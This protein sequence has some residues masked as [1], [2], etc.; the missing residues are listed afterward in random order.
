[1][2][3]TRSEAAGRYILGL[4]PAD[5]SGYFAVTE[6]V[7]TYGGNEV[8]RWTGLVRSRRTFKPALLVPLD[9]KVPQISTGATPQETGRILLVPQGADRVAGDLE[10]E[11]DGPE[12][13]ACLSGNGYAEWWLDIPKEATYQVFLRYATPNLR[14]CDIVIDGMDLNEHTMCALNKTGGSGPQDAFWELQGRV[15]LEPGLHW[16]RIQ[17]VLPDVVALRLEPVRLSSLGRRDHREVGIP[18]RPAHLSLTLSS[19][20]EGEGIGR[21]EIPW[22]P[23]AAP[24]PGFLTQ[25]GSWSSVLLF[26]SP[27]A[28]GPEE[29]EVRDATW[30]SLFRHLWQRGQGGDLRRGTRS[31]SSAMGRGTWSPLVSCSSGSRDRDLDT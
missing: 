3:P 9:V 4:E 18:E 30:S 6:A 14:P 2:C 16:I 1:M 24:D 25:K 17:D 5:T 21:K 20:G 15:C 28:R 22:Q 11:P 10:I 26:G 12:G 29:I 31:G 27:K 7:V 13:P 23:F 19:Q 8:G